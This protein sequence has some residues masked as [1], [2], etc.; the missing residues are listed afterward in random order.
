M[1]ELCQLAI[2]ECRSESSALKNKHHCYVSDSANKVS[3]VRNKWMREGQNSH[4]II[5]FASICDTIS[6]I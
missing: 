2:I 4:V 1:H 3:I 6:K 5:Y